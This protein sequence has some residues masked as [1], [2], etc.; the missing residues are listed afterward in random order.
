[1]PPVI[2]G[3]T[4][5]SKKWGNNLGGVIASLPWVAGPIILF[6]ALEQGADFA[7][8]AIPGVMV[9]IIA[10]LVFCMTY[11]VVGQKQNI[12]VSIMAGY[13]AYLLTGL[14]LQQVTPLFSVNLWYVI[15][16][17]FILPCLKFFPTV[18]TERAKSRKIL[19]FEIPLRMI[20]IT[21]FVLLIT[22]FA[23]LLGPTWSGILT[24]FPVMTAVLAIFVN[25]TQGISQ[26][27][28]IF[29]GQLTGI[30]GFTT[31]LYLQAHL[32][33]IMSIGNAFMIGIAVDIAITLIM[34]QVF[35]RIKFA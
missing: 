2:A 3:V 5:I 32:L 4:Y 11:I 16:L 20:M 30:F 15:T 29:I 22:Y 34:R 27:R 9:G 23:D 17:L 33:P 7:I 28:N 12:F 25:Y 26:V 6:I 31:F 8:S 18:K 10:W 35:A 21:L 19:R 24:P 13:M 14:A 1:M